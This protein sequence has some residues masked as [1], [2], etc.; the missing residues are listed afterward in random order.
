[1]VAMLLSDRVYPFCYYRVTAGGDAP[2][3]PTT[4]KSRAW[5]DDQLLDRLNGSACTSGSLDA[6]IEAHNREMHATNGTI[7]T[8]YPDVDERENKVA[9]PRKICWDSP[10]IPQEV[11]PS[12]VELV[13]QTTYHLYRLFYSNGSNSGLNAYTNAGTSYQCITD[14]V[15]SKETTQTDVMRKIEQVQI[16]K[17]CKVLR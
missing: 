4:E 7:D 1:M 3:I 15:D 10:T 2:E 9:M 12:A 13:R 16:T 14:P 11:I 8:I 6:A 5:F 17:N